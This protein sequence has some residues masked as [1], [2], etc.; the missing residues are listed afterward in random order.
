MMIY[1]IVFM[2]KKLLL[3]KEAKEWA[4][5]AIAK[6]LLNKTLDRYKRE[7]PAEGDR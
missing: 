1:F 2:K 5:L 3:T 6:S 7:R 4:K